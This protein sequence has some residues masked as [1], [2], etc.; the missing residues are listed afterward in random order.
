MDTVV[1]SPP[2]II[3]KQEVQELISI[4]RAALAAVQ[5]RVVKGDSIMIVGQKEKGI[6]SMGNGV[7]L[8]PEPFGRL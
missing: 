2:L 8:I 7:I 1:F 6:F 3:N 5:A 4:M